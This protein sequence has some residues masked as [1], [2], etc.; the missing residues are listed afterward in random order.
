LAVEYRPRVVIIENNRA[1]KPPTLWVMAYNPNHAWNPHGNRNYCGA[2]LE[3]HA[4]LGKR[5]GYAL[6]G[7]D[8]ND[9]NAIFVRRDLLERVRFPELTAAEAY[10]SGEQTWPPG[11]QPR[12]E[13][14]F[15]EQ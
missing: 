3:S 13:G 10:H 4:R 8:A 14:P 1:F 6:L 12:Y 5:L 2:S 15:V 7:T 9:I 11:W